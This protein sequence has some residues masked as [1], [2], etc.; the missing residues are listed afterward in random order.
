MGPRRRPFPVFLAFG[1]WLIALLILLPI[2][3]PALYRHR[4]ALRRGLPSLLPPGGA[5]HG[6]GSGAAHIGAQHQRHEYRADLL[7][8]PHPGIAAGSADLAQPLPATRVAGLLLA[9]GGVLTV[10]S[11]GDADVLARLAFGQGDLWVLLAATGWAFYTV[12][13]KR[14]PQPAVPASAKLAV[15]MAAGALALAPFAAVETLTGAAPAWS[16]PRL[17]AALLFLAIVPSLGAYACTAG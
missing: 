5:G 17:A 3:A 9:L 13:Q 1:R 7:V 10:L 15:M 14:L 2:A 4:Q 12:L 6:R 11:R 16:D 8:Q